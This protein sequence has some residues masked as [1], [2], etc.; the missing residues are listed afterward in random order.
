MRKRR[1]REGGGEKEKKREREREI[2]DEERVGKWLTL[3]LSDPTF[4]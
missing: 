3:A 4:S 2:K 1:E